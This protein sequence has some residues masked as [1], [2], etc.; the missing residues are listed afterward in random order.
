MEFILHIFT[1]VFIIIPTLLGYNLVFGKGKI[2]HFGQEGL[3]IAAVYALWVPIMQY[4][5][6]FLVGLLCSIIVV[7]AVALLL[8]FLSLR[9]E[10]DGFGV[11]S[12][13]LHLSLLAVV[14]NW[15]SVT[16]GALGIPRI[17]RFAFVESL[18]ALALMSFCIAV[19]CIAFMWW[20]DR[21]PFGRQI[22][23]L[24]EHPWNAESLGINR[25]NIHIIAFLI[26]GIG[27]LISNALFPMYLHLL[28]P[29]DY[30]FSVLIFLVM[31]VVA[32]GP[33]SI[34]GVVTAAFLLVFFR[35]GLRFVPLPASILGPM[36]HMLFGFIL[37]AAVWFRRDN[38][39]PPQRKI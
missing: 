25:R 13:A 11:M 35:E 12:I 15:Q 19:L 21:G 24:A 16:R 3:A 34:K 26:A 30:Q 5:L 4:N 2:L 33:G 36:R 27:A 18:E 38:I 28:S 9:M 37:F 7:S 8:A 20:L 39:F 14:L 23:A 32:G 6:P 29:T 10:Q 31:L 1:H 22:S 17:P